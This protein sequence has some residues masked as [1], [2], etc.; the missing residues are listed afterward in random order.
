MMFIEDLL[1]SGPYNY[2]SSQEGNFEESD[3]KAFLDRWFTGHKDDP[4]YLYRPGF[5]DDF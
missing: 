5:S 2:Y 4:V 1:G 3:L